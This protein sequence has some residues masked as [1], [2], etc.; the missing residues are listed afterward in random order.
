MKLDPEL[1]SGEFG[2]LRDEVTDRL[3]RIEQ[4]LD[5]RL[6]LLC[7]ELRTANLLAYL[8]LLREADRETESTLARVERLETEIQRRLALP[9]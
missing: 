4:Q 7:D 6:S 2:A 5:E 9:G 3:T 8:G 1:L